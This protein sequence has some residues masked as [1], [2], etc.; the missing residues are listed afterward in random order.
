MP[1]RATF[2]LGV[3]A[4]LLSAGSVGSQ[5]PYRARSEAESAATALPIY[6][7]ETFP[8]QSAIG[9]ASTLDGRA[10][11]A[12]TQLVPG[13]ASTSEI[14]AGPATTDPSETPVNTSHSV[15]PAAVSAVAVAAPA[16]ATFVPA[17]ARAMMMAREAPASYEP[18]AFETAT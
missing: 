4:V 17:Q 15:S 14:P 9:E 7:P 5:D 18:R 11:H 6:A 3:V 12:P 8:S 16:I 10:V 1:R 2:A 13:E